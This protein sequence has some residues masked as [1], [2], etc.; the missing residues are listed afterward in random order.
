MSV[1]APLDTT[2]PATWSVCPL[3]VKELLLG[4]VER[5]RE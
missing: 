1:P 5:S 4:F 2:Y 3:P